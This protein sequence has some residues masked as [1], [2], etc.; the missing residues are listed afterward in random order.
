LV[1]DPAAAGAKPML[2]PLLAR[3]QAWCN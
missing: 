1:R 2:K 3:L